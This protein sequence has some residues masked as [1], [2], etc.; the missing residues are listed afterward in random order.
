VIWEELAAG[1]AGF[2]VSY[3]G[4]VTTLA[5]WMNAAPEEHLENF[6]RPFAESKEG[7]LVAVATTE[8]NVG[9]SWPIIFPDEF[10]METTAVLD[11]N[12]WVLN[13]NKNFCTNG[14]TPLTRWYLI[15]ARTDM[16]KTGLEAHAGFAV[17]ADT[18][19]FKFGPPE[20][21]MGQRLSYNASFF[22]DDL[23]IP[24]ENFV[25]K[26]S[27]V[28]G[29]KPR[30]TTLDPFGTIGGLFLGIARSAFEESLEYA[31]NRMI[32]GKPQIQYQLIAA[33]LADMFIEIEAAR[34]LVWKSARYSDTHPEADPKLGFAAKVFSSDVCVRTTNEAVQIH[35][36]YGY[37]KDTLV[38]KL[39]RDA[40]V[41]QIYEGPNEVLRLGI[42]MF[43]ELGV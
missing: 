28:M 40:K 42:G 8:P 32:V 36:G 37:S 15:Y 1:D 29:V 10:A 23:S 31:K 24:K 6:I 17:P 34:S 35:G 21:K 27:E 25:S 11:G 12:E 3:E 26:N 9:P 4:H 16:E 33:K 13:G 22:L 5:F 43:L 14:G 39:Y 38:E 2:C 18:P 19:G 30:Q 7:G 41:T 20:H